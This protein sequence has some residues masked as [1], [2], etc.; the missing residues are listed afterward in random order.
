MSAE[1]REQ[2]R[3]KIGIVMQILP[4]LRQAQKFA[5]SFALPQPERGSLQCSISAKDKSVVNDI[6]SVIVVNDF[7]SPAPS[8][9]FQGDR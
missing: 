7:T 9:S 1:R 4:Q 2:R 3:G 5:R 6:S 8:F